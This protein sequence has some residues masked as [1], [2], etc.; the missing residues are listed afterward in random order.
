[1]KKLI[2]LLLLSTFTF[3]SCKDDEKT[4]DNPPKTINLKTF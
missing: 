4:N 1:M 2:T 3:I